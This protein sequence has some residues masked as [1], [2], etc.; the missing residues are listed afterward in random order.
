M[1]SLGRKEDFSKIELCDLFLIRLCDSALKI[2]KL[3]TLYFLAIV[4]SVTRS[5]AVPVTA[6]TIFN[7]TSAG[8]I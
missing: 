1:R 8:S 6:F 5:L 3:K 4:I 7:A 2:N